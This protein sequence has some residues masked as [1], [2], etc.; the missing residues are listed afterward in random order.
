LVWSCA[1]NERKYNSQKCAIY[2]NLETTRQRGRPKKRWQD[3]VREGGKLDGRNRWKERVY[4]RK[5]WKKP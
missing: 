1:E 3:K 2:I 5:E 4:S